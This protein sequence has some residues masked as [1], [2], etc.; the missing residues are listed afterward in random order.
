[1]LEEGYIQA[2]DYPRKGEPLTPWPLST[3]LIIARIATEW[4]TLGKGRNDLFDIVWFIST[5]EGDR[6]LAEGQ[7]RNVLKEP[8]HPE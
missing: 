1:M 6:I 8:D 3:Q 7:E 5:M 2:G 4:D